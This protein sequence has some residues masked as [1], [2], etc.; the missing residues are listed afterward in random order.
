MAM[1]STTHDPAAHPGTRIACTR[2]RPTMPNLNDVFDERLW[3]SW[4]CMVLHGQLEWK[5]RSKA[6]GVALGA[7]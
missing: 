1:I 7:S 4:H 2:I 5:H 6:H 3:M